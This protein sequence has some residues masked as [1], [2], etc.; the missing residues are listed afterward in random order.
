MKLFGEFFC[1]LLYGNKMDEDNFDMILEITL[2]AL[3]LRH[4]IRVIRGGQVA[5]GFNGE[6]GTLNPAQYRVA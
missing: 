1:A 3:S 5:C 6:Q 4:G 2:V